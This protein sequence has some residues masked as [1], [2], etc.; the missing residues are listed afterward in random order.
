[1]RKTFSEFCRC[2]GRTSRSFY[3]TSGALLFLIKH[4]LDRIVASSLGYSWTILDYWVFVEGGVPRLSTQRAKL[5]A[6]LV[7]IAL[8]F[9]WVGIVLTVR[10]L[11]DA[12]LPTWWLIFFFTPFL[13]L[14]FFALLSI[15]PSRDRPKEV[16]PSSAAR[17]RWY[18]RIIP[19][20]EFGSAAFGVA[21][22]SLLALVFAALS[23]YWLEEYGWGLFVG[24]PFF[25]GLN[26]VLI[27]GYHEPRPLRNCLGVTFLSVGLVAGVIFLLAVEGLLCIIMAAPLAILLAFLGGV[28][29]YFL[30]L[31]NSRAASPIL[32]A[33]FL[34]P[35]VI[36]LEPFVSRQPAQYEVRTS[37]GIKAER[38]LVW[39]NVVSFSA[40]PPPRELIFKTGI[41]FPMRA[42]IHG[43]G[44]GAIRHCIFSTGEFVEPITI[45]D[46]PRVLKFDVVSQPRAMDEL[47]I[48][49]NL[50][51]RHVTDYLVSR[52]GQFLLKETAN[53]ETLLEGTTT[54]E[55]RFWPG[56]YWRLWSD[57]IIHR[58][59]S[60][61]LNHIKELS[62][63]KGSFGCEP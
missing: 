19:R 7:L 24:I 62:E 17:R 63:K 44:V 6:L 60:R 34:L 28:F 55:I 58:I 59:H 41:A 31:R 35:G 5:Y 15:V 8:P 4:N 48:Y 46:E 49:S 53:G 11:R 12:A 45:W 27:Y 14:I 23:I 10:R 40:L 22:T 47:S 39:K 29:G 16:G 56:P 25:L 30:Q 61:V 1:M 37:V 42:E 52:Q 2:R 36:A 54:Y 18:S 26:S 21:M 20:S 51:P 38:P 57:F 9:I 43:Q 50:R 32:P 33:V 3:A 13:N